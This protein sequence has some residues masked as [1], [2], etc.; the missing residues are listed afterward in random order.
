M[1]TKEGA[2]A[3]SKA[4]LMLNP[5]IPGSG[6]ATRIKQIFNNDR[7]GDKLNMFNVLYMYS[8]V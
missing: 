7:K 2:V 4:Q 3:G 5:K 6:S 8:T 1:S